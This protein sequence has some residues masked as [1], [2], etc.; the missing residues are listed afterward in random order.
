[1]AI[2]CNCSAD[3]AYEGAHHDVG[4]P[5]WRIVPRDAGI[6]DL[7]RLGNEH[8]L[9]YPKPKYPPLGGEHPLELPPSHLPPLGGEHPLSR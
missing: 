7:P 4:C 6:G 1:M 9:S 8:P 2:K 5:Y 3:S